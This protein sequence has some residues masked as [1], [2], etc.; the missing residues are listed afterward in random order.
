MLIL[1]IDPGLAHC[2]WGVISCSGSRLSACAYGTI[3]TSPQDTL[4]VRLAVIFNDLRAVI[5]RYRPSELGI[6][7]V[8][9]KGNSKS[10]IATAQARGAA[11]AAV[12][13]RNL[14]IGEYA[15]AAVKM[16]VVGEGSASKKQVQYMVRAILGLDHEPSPDHAADALAVAICHAHLRTAPR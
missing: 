10:A 12:A 1:G 11:L 6:E 3:V 14:P 16:S 7:T 9:H 5:E 13:D 2:G 15:P 4:P 8:Y